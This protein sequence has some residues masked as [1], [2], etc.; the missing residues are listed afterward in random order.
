MDMIIQA[1]LILA[2]LVIMFL[3]N[4]GWSKECCRMNNDWYEF[5]LKYNQLWSMNVKHLENKVAELEEQ[6]KKQED[7]S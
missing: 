2:I 7:K 3:V 1:I 5:C 4:H 6:I